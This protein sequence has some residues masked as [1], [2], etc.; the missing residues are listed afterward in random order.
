MNNLSVL[1]KTIELAANLFDA[2]KSTLA[3]TDQRSGKPSARLK[4]IKQPF[5]RVSPESQGISSSYIL[6]FIKELHADRT[7]DNHRLMILR[8]GKVISDAAFGLQDPSLWKMT[9]SAAK[10]VTALAIG[11]LVDG[12]KVSLSDKVAKFFEKKLAP[13]S[14]ITIKDLTV[15]DLLTMRSCLMFAEASAMV[16]T[17]WQKAFL[18][19]VTTGKIGEDFNYNSLNS[20][21]LAAIVSSVTGESLSDF[22]RK[23][24]FGPM[25]IEDFYWETCP[26]G[27]EKGGWGLYMH[28]ED[29][30]KLG[31]LVLNKGL[32]KGKRLLSEEWISAMT[33]THV[34]TPESYGN[35]NYGYHIW[36]G[37]DKN[38]FLF[39]GM[40]G[41]N[42][43]GFFDNGIILVSN[44]GNEEIFQSSNYYPVAEKY[45]GKSFPSSLPENEEEYK[46]LLEATA[47]LRPQKEQ[48]PEK[49]LFGFFRKKQEPT[50][51]AEC[52][53]L[54]GKGFRPESP[55]PSLG[56]MPVTL[57]ATQNNYTTGLTKI[58]LELCDGSDFRIIFS[59]GDATYLLPVGFQVPKTTELSF[60]GEPFK[61]STLGKFGVDE[62]GNTVLTLHTAFVETPF[63]RRIKI[64]F[65]G[66][67]QGAKLEVSEQPGESYLLDLAAMGL[68]N[69]EEVPV[70]SSI[71]SK[72]N[73]DYLEY[74][75]NRI[76]EPEAELIEI[77]ESA[78]SAQ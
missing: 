23:A 67:R 9:F 2:K 40:F 59:E 18:N 27:I 15:E 11:L 60:N 6:D 5:E 20:Y 49:R 46:K 70:I 57:Q 19:S 68:K 58:S 52:K 3:V 66:T 62:D 41:Q 39:N 21:M 33:S 54:N 1:N 51:P 13:L 72:T 37:K 43:L 7:L 73:M 48:K 47:A 10:S 8:N 75:V 31:Q 12:G 44:A 14:K 45:F 26:E 17:D 61:V 42:V 22:L 63:T 76:M 50:I 77:S 34:L 69:L 4:E 32:W 36:V 74:K 65:Y 24:L 38:T 55:C 35:Y 30:A 25:G 16:E 29:M 28:A 71:V 78:N 56:L 64:R 53:A